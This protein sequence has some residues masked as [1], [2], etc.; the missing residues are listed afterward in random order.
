V[1]TDYHKFGSEARMLPG[2]DVMPDA[3]P[4]P[5]VNGQTPTPPPN[6]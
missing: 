2:F 4:S 6:R 3:T 1:Y 5:A